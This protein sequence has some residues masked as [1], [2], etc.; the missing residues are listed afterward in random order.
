MTKLEY[1]DHLLA[2][3]DRQTINMLERLAQINP[4]ANRLLKLVGHNRAL[5]MLFKNP[6]SAMTLLVGNWPKPDQYQSEELPK[7]ALQGV[8]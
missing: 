5:D 1:L 4:G 3:K 2:E 7:E 6:S 8:A